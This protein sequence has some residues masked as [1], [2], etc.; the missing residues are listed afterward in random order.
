MEEMWLVGGHFFD[1]FLIMIF[2]F[3]SNFLMNFL[4]K[5]FYFKKSQDDPNWHVTHF[6]SF[7][8]FSLR[9]IFEIFSS[10]RFLNIIEVENKMTRE[11]FSSQ[12][13]AN[14]LWT[15]ST[16]ERERGNFYHALLPTV[17]LILTTS[18]KGNANPLCKYFD[19]WNYDSEIITQ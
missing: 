8:T 15:L 18:T 11:N 7:C 1:T 14:S 16:F 13:F 6:S 19:C 2:I 12:V 10:F 5:I 17:H 4:I 9:L 3:Y